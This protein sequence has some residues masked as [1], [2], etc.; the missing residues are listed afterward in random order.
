MLRTVINGAVGGV[1][2]TLKTRYFKSSVANFLRHDGM[3]N[4]GVMVIYDSENRQKQV[5]AVRICGGGVASTIK[6]SNHRE[7]NIVAPK[8]GRGEMG[9]LVIYETKKGKDTSIS[10]RR[11]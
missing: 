9:V 2:R 10:A 3:G 11:E 6:T 4:T 1:A 5:D 7:L 8:G